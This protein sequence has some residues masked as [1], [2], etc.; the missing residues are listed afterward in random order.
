MTLE[1]T[2][3]LSPNPATLDRAS[4]LASPRKWIRV[5]R[6]DR[7]LWG[8]C[9]GT[10]T[11]YQSIVDMNGPAYKCT[12]PVKQFPCKHTLALLLMAAE[13]PD[14]A[15]ALTEPP[16]WVTEWIEKR[17]KK[18]AAKEVVKTPEQLERS[19]ANKERS[20]ALR[21]K[22]MELG[23]ADIK[24]RLTDIIREGLASLEKAPADFWKDFAS[25]M[26][27]AQLGGLAKRIKALAAFVGKEDNWHEQLL[28]TLSAFYLFA[29]AFEHIDEIPDDLQDHML[30]LAGVS[31][32][33]EELL[34]QDGVIDDW[35]VLGQM[36][37]AE[38]DS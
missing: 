21:L 25:R 31:I 1:Q 32:K 6:N 24:S 20:Q 10:G 2:Q 14:T 27:D 26:V 18:A 3:S 29:K 36:E 35:L 12:C 23:V 19:A 30:A 5:E 15:F 4:H 28:E 7:A 38:E 34:S 13:A 33:K 17:D 11:V 22:T 8:E 9:S 16:A 37:K